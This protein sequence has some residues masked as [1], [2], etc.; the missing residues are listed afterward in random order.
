MRIGLI[1]YG[2]GNLF[3]LH[4]ALEH[5]G[6]QVVTIGREENLSEMDHLI[7]PGV[8][9]FGTGMAELHTRGLVEPIRIYAS[10]GR[11]LLGICLGAQLMLSRG[12]EFGT[13]E[14][15]CLLAGQVKTIRDGVK[16]SPI[17]GWAPLQWHSDEFAEFQTD[18]MYFVHSFA[19]VPDDSSAILASR[20]TAGVT[21]VA[22]IHEQSIVGLQFHPEKSG[23]RGLQLLNSILKRKI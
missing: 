10:E 13:H 8:G 19:M 11:P 4:S 9:A 20:A 23:P 3:S 5:L 16:P 18:W 2:A 6:H 17:I 15:L 7:L 12:H 22:A 14:G 1:D 21:Y